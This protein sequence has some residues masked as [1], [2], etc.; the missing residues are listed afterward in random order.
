[1]VESGFEVPRAAEKTAY[2]IEKGVSAEV[3]TKVMRQAQ[4]ER[5]GG[6]KVLVMRM[7][8][9]KKFQKEQLKAQGYTDFQEFYREEL[10]F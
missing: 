2:L 6:K 7:N 9:N 5:E 8:K 3:M 10:K 4:K 1:M